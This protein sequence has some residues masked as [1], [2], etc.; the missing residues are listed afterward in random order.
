MKWWWE[1]MCWRVTGLWG[2][3]SEMPSLCRPAVTPYGIIPTVRV[4]SSQVH[5]LWVLCANAGP[6]PQGYE[7][8]M[9]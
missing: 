1:R 7:V 4:E 2:E 9:Y 3:P 8:T 6:A 5:G